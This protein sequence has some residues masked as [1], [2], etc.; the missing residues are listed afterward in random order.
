[1]CGQRPVAVAEDLAEAVEPAVEHEQQFVPL[2]AE[3]RE[4]LVALDDAVVLV[5]V[6]H[7]QMAPVGGLVVHLVAQVDVAELEVAVAAQ[8]F[9]VIAGDDE[10]PAPALGLGEHAP[11]HVGERLRPV[12]P[13]LEAPAVDHVADQVETLA[14]VLLEEVRQ[15]GGAAAARA[16]CTSE[17][18]ML[19][20]RSRGAG[21]VPVGAVS[22]P[23]S[24][25]AC[26]M[27][28]SAGYAAAWAVVESMRAAHHRH[29][30]AT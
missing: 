10:H 24:G 9:V 29:L 13:G 4:P 15:R 11:D 5:A 20:K 18:Q 1:M 28:C 14:V 6:D 21:G 26:G 22:D 30:N 16:R 3:E 12:A 2:V 27:A 7:Q 25:G 17:I 23:G 19:R 8:E